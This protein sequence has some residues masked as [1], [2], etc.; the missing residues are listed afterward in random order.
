MSYSHW[1]QIGFLFRPFHGHTKEQ[2][3]FDICNQ[4]EKERRN[5]NLEKREK[6]HQK[7]RDKTW[8][9]VHTKNDEETPWL[10]HDQMPFSMTQKYRE[11]KEST[12]TELA[13]DTWIQLEMLI[14]VF[15]LV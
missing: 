4:I 10:F 5:K 12:P 6:C 13:T 11:I 9:R 1:K 3:T 2:L 15:A 7:R 14:T 8:F